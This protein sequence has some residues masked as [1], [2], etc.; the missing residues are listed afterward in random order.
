MQQAI[1]NERSTW[2]CR[3][4]A[5][6]I[7]MLLSECVYDITEQLEG[8]DEDPAVDNAVSQNLCL[9]VLANSRSISFDYLD[10]VDGSFTISVETV[11]NNVLQF[12]GSFT[13]DQLEQVTKAVYGTLSDYGVMLREQLTLE[14]VT[15]DHLFN[16]S[17]AFEI[18]TISVSSGFGTYDP[19]VVFNV[20]DVTA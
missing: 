20:G 8:F 2:P 4:L 13:S 7:G 17:L 12:G 11:G 14:Q 5:R 19:I 10:D 3:V 15:T 18:D 6:K 9:L 1:K 16:H